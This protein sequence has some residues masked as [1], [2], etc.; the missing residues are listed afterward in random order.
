VIVSMGCW[1]C[2][3]FPTG[4]VL[5]YIYCTASLS[6]CVRKYSK[7]FGANLYMGKIIREKFLD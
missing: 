6:T 2:E 4:N 5:N 3:S 1:L 7:F